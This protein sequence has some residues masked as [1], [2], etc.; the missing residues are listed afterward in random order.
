M[1]EGRNMILLFPTLL[2]LSE[3]DKKN[4]EARCVASSAGERLCSNFPFG[5]LN[6]V[7]LLRSSVPLLLFQQHPVPSTQSLTL[8]R[9]CHMFYSRRVL[10]INDGKPKWTGIN[11]SSELI[12]DTP[13]ELK[14]KKRKEEQDQGSKDQEKEMEG[15]EN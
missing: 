15:E 11:N 2:E 7:S 5:L 14:H 3:E 4:F 8:C 6:P 12:A 10:D 9:S 1:D 13:E